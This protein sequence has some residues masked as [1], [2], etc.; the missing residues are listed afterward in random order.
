MPPRLI[1]HLAAWLVPRDLRARWREEWLAEIAV[2]RDRRLRHALGAPI[3]AAVARWRAVRQALT[4]SSGAAGWR[5]DLRDGFR[6]LARTPL[7]TVTIVVCLAV[8]SALT[9][10]MFG[11]VNAM[12]H[13]EL[14]GV[15]DRDRL[16]RVRLSRSAHLTR[17]TF[18]AMPP[19]PGLSSTGAQFVAGELTTVIDGRGVPASGSFVSG[20]FFP[21]LGTTPVIGRLLQPADDRPDAPPVV[22]IGHGFWQREFGGRQDAL[23]TAIRVNTDTFQ[24]VGVAPAGFPGLDHGHPGDDV[25]GR[26]EVWLPMGGM[27]GVF[28]AARGGGWLLVGRLQDGLTTQDARAQAGS[29]VVPLPPGRVAFEPQ[30]PATLVLSRFD[31][32]PF[33]DDEV[34]ASVLL[35]TVLMG[36]PLVVLA[37]ACANVAGV[38]LARATG[39]THELA[40]RV[41][42]GASRWR[43]ARGLLVETALISIAAGAAAWLAATRLLELSGAVL[44]FAASADRRV[45]WFSIGL[46]LV[47]SM[48]AGLLPAWHATGFEPTAGLRLGPRVGR[49]ASR[50]LRRATVVTQ[51]ALS[52][53]LLIAAGTLIRAFGTLPSTIGTAHE[54]VFTAEVSFYGLGVN[55]AERLDAR[56]RLVD[57]M[58][59]VPGVGAVTIS[60]APLFGSSGGLRC[61]SDA[62]QSEYRFALAAEVA[63]AYFDLIDLPVLQGRTFRDG[64]RRGVV[65]LNEA[66]VRTLGGATPLAGL[67]IGV[68]RGDGRTGVVEPARVVGIV[69]DSYERRPRGR[70]RPMCYVPIDPDAPSDYFT[71]YARAS[72]TASLGPLVQRA[73]PAIDERL[74][75]REAGTIAERLQSNYRWLRWM[76]AGVG[77]TGAAALM[78]AAVGL[79]GVVGYGAALR[80]HEFGVRL[81]LGAR[82]GD[83]A[84]G[85]VR[86]SVG[87]S[88]AGVV[89]GAGLAIPVAALF[90][91]SLFVNV[92]L[93]DPLLLLTAA[94]T[95]GAVSLAAAVLPARRAAAIDP[96]RSLRAE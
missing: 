41:A 78:I 90:R 19:I 9:V 7:Q 38:Q 14:P 16:V 10:T 69:A 29:V 67:A 75:A 31:L 23:G 61:E 39:R 4:P 12:I 36:L 59:A 25:E 37:I 94:G 1:V 51:L 30:T 28:A 64:E 48:L 8:G 85:V 88:V 82:P 62:M 66:F 84:S 92:P 11:V 52:V 54:H 60:T 87:T 77:W 5:M 71:L 21:T 57:T 65:V 53:M 56:R 83:V 3:D 6:S 79:F 44:P 34:L 50:R 91:A 43:V 20:T 70:P 55:P 42:L 32:L 73:L 2:A 89:I 81:A 72:D 93:L 49:V 63:P 86:E 68:R 17:A 40:V 35:V 24:I 18:A 45:L 27:F 96:V 22:V 74:A 95:L 33:D 15:R 47:V 46:P 76:S 80:S 58:A 26:G 13:G